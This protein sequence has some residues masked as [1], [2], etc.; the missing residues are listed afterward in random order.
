MVLIPKAIAPKL[1]LVSS[2]FRKSQDGL[3]VEDTMT[4]THV[5]I[6]RI[7]ILHENNDK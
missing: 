6:Q 1:L 5:D 7:L 2:S 3:E 4:H